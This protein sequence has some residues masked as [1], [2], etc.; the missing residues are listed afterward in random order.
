MPMSVRPLLHDGKSPVRRGVSF[1]PDSVDLA[2]SV[3]PRS[4]NPV[5]TIH[6]AAAGVEDDRVAQIGRFDA[7]RVLSHLTTGG[8]AVTE[9]T[10]LV[11]LSDFGDGNRHHRQALGCSPEALGPPELPKPGDDAGVGFSL[12]LHRASITHRLSAHAAIRAD[13][14]MCQRWSMLPA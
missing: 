1:E 3:E 5:T 4:R 2:A 7:T 8:R 6:Q 13:K 10:V 11:E 9:P 14:P 12:T